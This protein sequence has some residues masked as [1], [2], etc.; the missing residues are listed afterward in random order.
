MNLQCSECGKPAV[1]MLGEYY[2]WFQIYT[3]MIF[4]H[5]EDYIT[6]ALFETIINSLMHLKPEDVDD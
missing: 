2:Y 1:E 6:D 3:F 5:D 4:L